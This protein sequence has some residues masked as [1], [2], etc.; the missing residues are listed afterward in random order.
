MPWLTVITSSPSSPSRPQIRPS[1]SN[2]TK[3]SLL[4]FAFS[5][6]RHASQKHSI[7]VTS[8]ITATTWRPWMVQTSLRPCGLS[9]W[10]R[11]LSAAA[12]AHTTI[13]VRRYRQATVHAESRNK[14]P[15]ISNSLLL[16]ARIICKRDSLSAI[17][18]AVSTLGFYDSF[19]KR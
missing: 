4:L 3:P 7:T 9:L 2:A 1:D 14:T 15:F 17:A 10:L 6:V 18:D 5:Q 11:L 12:S 16:G 19:Q 13:N 8:Q